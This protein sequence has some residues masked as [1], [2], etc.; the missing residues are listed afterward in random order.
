MEKPLAVLALMTLL[1][2]AS[3]DAEIYKWVD[4]KGKVHFSDQQP[5]EST[6]A[7][8]IKEKAHHSN[9]K[10]FDIQIQDLSESLTDT[11]RQQITRDVTSIYWVY[12]RILFFDMYKTVP[13]HITLLPSEKSY[14]DYLRQKLGKNAPPSLGMYLGKLNEIVV[15][16]Q[17]DRART[18]RTINHETSHAIVD[19]VTPFVSAWLNEGLAEQMELLTVAHGQV[20]IGGDRAHFRTA[21]DGYFNGS[22]PAL[23]QFLTLQSGTWKTA[24][25]HGGYRLQSYTGTF[26]FFLLNTVPGRNLLIRLIHAYERGDKRLA[27]SLVDELYTGGTDM[28]E[29]QWQAFLRGSYPAPLVLKP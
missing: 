3:V 6:Q 28:L 27:V 9:W 4:A 7:E 17:E 18:F 23:R 26:C 12:D 2:A 13:V 29:V 16:L 10:T 15:Y 19:T 20:V 24:N 1:T 25:Q 8:Q 5:P 22:L 14:Y 11:E 21:R